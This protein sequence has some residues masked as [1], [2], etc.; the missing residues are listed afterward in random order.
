LPSA[1]PRSDNLGWQAKTIHGLQRQGGTTKSGVAKV[2][3]AIDENHIHPCL[4]EKS[5]QFSTGWSRTYHQNL[6]V[7][8]LADWQG[9]DG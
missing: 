9:C 5:G 7:G 2:V 4:G 3:E 8:W 1:P 6:A